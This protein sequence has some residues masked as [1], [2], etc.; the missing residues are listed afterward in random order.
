MFNDS[1]T[2]EADGDEVTWRYRN[3]TFIAADIVYHLHEDLQTFLEMW[4]AQNIVQS[5]VTRLSRTDH[6]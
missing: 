6:P 5:Y 3:V 4:K 1:K 2:I